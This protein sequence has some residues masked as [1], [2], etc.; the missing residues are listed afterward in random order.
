MAPTTTTI[1][2]EVKDNAS[3]VLRD[4][5]SSLGT[6]GK[7]AGVAFGVKE[8][9]Q[10]LNSY[11]EFSNR[12][13][14]ATSS[15]QE[16]TAVQSALTNVAIKNYT[17]LSNT[18]DLYARLKLTTGDYNITQNDLIKL[19]DT[20]TASFKIN[21]VSGQAQQ[22]V[23]DN[24]GKSFLKG[25]IDGR[26]FNQILA[27][28]PDILKRYS[29]A[30]GLTIQQLYKLAQEGRLS[31]E[32]LI[33][34]LQQTA[35][36]AA[37]TANSQEATLGQSLSNLSTQFVLTIG[38]I[39]EA[40]GFTRGLSI[41]LDGLSKNIDAVILGLGVF[42]TVLA[43]GK[44]VAITTAVGGLTKAFIG[45]GAAIRA[46][47]G[48]GIV[49]ALLSIAA[50][51]GYRIYENLTKVETVSNAIADNWMDYLETGTQIDAVNRKILTDFDKYVQ[52]IESASE[53]N[54]RLR[55]IDQARLS[56]GRQ[57]TEEE[58]K[59]LN[60]ALDQKELREAE[61]KLPAII[62]QTRGAYST[63][64]AEQQALQ[65][66]LKTLQTLRDNDIENEATYLRDM[67]I[68]QEEY[69]RKKLETNQ[70]TIDQMVKQILAGNAS[71]IQIQKLSDQDKIK[72]AMSTGL[73][74]LN[75]AGQYNKT[76]FNAAKALAISMAI[77]NGIDATISSYRTGSQLGGP[78]LGAVFAAV[79]AASIAAQISKIRSTQY[80]GARRQG[81]LVGENQSYL[82]GES[83]PEMFTPSSSGRITPNDQMS[84]GVTVNFNISTVD[85]DGFDEILINRRSTIVGIINEATNKRGRVGA[86]Q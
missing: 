34:A 51:E 2:V 36:Q 57:L 82:V 70:K 55:D 16:F 29:Q 59:R 84:Q 49:A 58:Q 79:T 77:I 41:I 17:S 85:A 54:Q 5:G 13:K 35:A 47:P 72:L 62:S 83:G 22:S 78:I 33:Q 56:L 15:V 24:L 27:T 10:A 67:M 21:G 73:E 43:V 76:A 61:S 12:V 23:I 19:T 18:A 11:Q 48:V 20:L 44:I 6:I 7:L 65:E 74:L 60:I 26:D 40:T 66:K 25:T 31:S 64:S 50:V 39:N 71:A 69:D 45:L 4:I 9:A 37:A 3:K 52:K 68:L 38:K 53:T 30:T 28:A 14:N 1:N 63:G 46:I 75:E 8:I 32:G 81:G 86:T 80:T 42:F